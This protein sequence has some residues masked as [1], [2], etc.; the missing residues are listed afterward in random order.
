MPPPFVEGARSQLVTLNL[1]H[2]VARKI[3]RNAAYL[4]A[5]AEHLAGRAAGL[6]DA[7][8]CR[9]PPPSPCYKLLERERRKYPQER[10]EA[11]VRKILGFIVTRVL[12]WE[13]KI[14]GTFQ[15]NIRIYCTRYRIFSACVNRERRCTH[16]VRQSTGASAPASC[17]L[18]S[19]TSDLTRR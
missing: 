4:L 5:V 15:E 11:N 12:I 13:K 1:S 8:S 19:R 7:L 14:S 17:S 9:C 16:L 10:H 3:W 6:L 18:L 2:F